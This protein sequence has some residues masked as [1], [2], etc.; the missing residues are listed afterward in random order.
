M[1]YELKK[2]QSGA[3][4]IISAMEYNRLSKYSK[5]LYIAIQE[6][7]VNSNRKRF[8]VDDYTPPPSS[9]YTLPDLSAFDIT[10]SPDPT[11]DNSPSDFGGFGG[12]D[13]GGSG[14]GGD[15]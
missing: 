1:Y 10:S 7:P 12:G 8:N 3:K 9:S 4:T 14:A 13:G 6:K 11:P 2:P 5:S 15:Y